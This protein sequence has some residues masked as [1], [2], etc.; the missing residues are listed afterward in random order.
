MN[1]EEKSNNEIMAAQIQM[2]EEFEAKKSQIKELAIKHNKMMKELMQD[3]DNLDAKFLE[4]KKVLDS[5]LSY[6]Q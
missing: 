3:L 2:K 6:K 5:R 1:W 4:S